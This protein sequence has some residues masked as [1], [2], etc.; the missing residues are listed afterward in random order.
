MKLPKQFNWLPGVVFAALSSP[1]AFSQ[2]TIIGDNY[3]VTGSGTGFNLNQGV[4]A[5][6]NPPATRL[7]GNAASGLRYLYTQGGTP[8]A[9][10]AYAISDHKLVVAAAPNSGRFTL[11][12]N[13]TTP[14]DFASALGVESATPATPVVYDI[15]IKMANALSG[16]T[17][18][19]FGF[20]THETT[21]DN[22]DFC[23]QLWRTNS[24]ATRYWIQKRIDTGSSGVADLNAHITRLAADSYGAE[25]QFLIRVTDAGAESGANY[26][27]RVQVSINGGATWIYDTN[28]DPDLP[29]GWRFDGP[30]R[31]FVWDQAGTS[32]SG[33]VSYDDFLV[34]RSVAF[35]AM[36]VS[37]PDATSDLGPA[38]TLSAAVSNS[39]AGDL[40]VTFYGREAPKPFPGPDF[41]VAV[42]PDTQNYAREASGSGQAVKEMWFSQTEWIVTNR[43]AHNIAYVAHLGDIVQNGDIKN[44]NPNTTEWRNAT[45]AMYRLENPARTLLPYGVPYGLAVGNHD[46]QPI[47]DPDG[48]T[49][50]YNQYFGIDRFSGRP[51]YGGYF[52]SNNDSHFDLFSA[53]GLDFIVL[54]FEFG[55]Y[56]SAILNWANAVLATNQ[57]R[58]AIAVTHYA[59][60]DKTPSSFSAQGSAIYNALKG[61]TNFFMMLGGHVA[62]NGGEGW[63]VNTYEGRTVRTFISDYQ[64]R[65]NGGNG[66]MRLMYFSPSNNTVVIQTYS[67]WLD[68]YETDENSEMFFSYNLQ[69]PTGPGSPGT[70]YVAIATN[71]G[72]APATVTSCSWGGL[73]AHKTYD[74]YVQVRDGSGNL[75]STDP[76]R[77]TTKTKFATNTRPVANGQLV[78]VPDDAP[79]AL[80]LQASDADG[81]PLTFQITGQPLGGLITDFDPVTG[82]VTY[83]PARG[84]QGPDRIIFVAN[85]GMTNSAPATANLIVA[86]P[87]DSNGNGLPDAWETA[88]GVTD[89]DAD[90][91][92]D[93]RSNYEEYRANTNPTNAASV[94]RLLE[95]VQHPNGDVD[96]TWS[97]LGGTRYRVQ[98]TDALGTGS[99]VDL[100]RTVSE[101]MDTGP[102]GE[103]S[104]QTFTDTTLP[105]GGARYYRIRLVP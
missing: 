47:G 25:V 86:A 18:F 102:Y 63:R 4:N 41:C 64:G 69:L 76:W 84:Y 43:V 30:A 61:Q 44:G 5:G 75:I 15:S 93:G 8:K 67:P 49:T 90:D 92:G 51:Y 71:S 66:W 46:Q 60:S 3:N 6:I 32:G 103:E 55:R 62:S 104:T 20:G 11:S 65:L 58:R 14:F 35:A 83:L 70:P 38:V 87:P 13:G 59:G 53:S 91:D 17:R 21:V 96:I 56:G 81:D 82:Q 78:T 105:A 48:T 19:S 97:S 50:H 94:L 9:T 98:Y 26:N 54:Y 22:Q 33:L 73:Q 85:D 7:T 10:T 12:A 31:Y 16:T 40:T 37:P 68:R 1:V 72:V 23:L 100:L 45:N 57:H 28:T 24:T 80:T 39:V 77:F 29:N 42:L 101:E 95:V 99:M 89:P 27:S 74:W 79:T 88:Y 36:P 2:S 34:T 52:G